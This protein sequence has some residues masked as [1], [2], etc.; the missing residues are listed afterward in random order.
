MKKSS[1]KSRMSKAIREINLKDWYLILFVTILMFQTIYNLFDS[2]SNVQYSPIDT[3]IRTTLAGLFGYFMGKGFAKGDK[4]RLIISKELIDIEKEIEELEN[5]T[6]DDVNDVEKQI[7][8]E[9]TQSPTNKKAELQILIVGAIGIM[10]LI[11]LIVARNWSILSTD[12]I[13]TLSQLRDL[14]SGSTGFLISGAEK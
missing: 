5:A 10:S 7:V 12:N 13:A 11:V 9:A 2:P 1:L 3:A 8:I 6:K 4:E 14:V